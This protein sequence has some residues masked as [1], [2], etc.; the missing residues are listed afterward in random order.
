MSERRPTPPRPPRSAWLRV[1]EDY[2]LAADGE[3]P[4]WMI[5]AALALGGLVGASVLAIAVVSGVAP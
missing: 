1:F 3:H 5:V 4:W 2:D